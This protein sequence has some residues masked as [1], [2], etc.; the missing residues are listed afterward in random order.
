M[1]T[2]QVALQSWGT[3]T[4]TRLGTTAPATRL[5]LEA[6]GLAPPPGYAVS[7]V[8]AVGAIAVRLKTT[9]LTPVA[10]TGLPELPTLKVSGVLGVIGRDTVPDPLHWLDAIPRPMRVSQ[11]RVGA[12]GLYSPAVPDAVVET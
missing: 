6:V 8:L 1:V 2:V 10:G 3:G 11:I 4:I 12:V 5:T 7:T 9:A